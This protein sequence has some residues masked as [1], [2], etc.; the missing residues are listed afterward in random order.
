MSSS[1]PKTPPRRTEL[2][3]EV[4]LPVEDPGRF[5][6][7]WELGLGGRSIL[8]AAV[9]EDAERVGIKRSPF[10]RMVVLPGLLL[11][12]FTGDC[13]TVVPVPVND[14]SLTPKSRR[15]GERVAAILHFGEVAVAT[16]G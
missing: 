5:P 11:L 10:M 1:E 12:F 14:H 13:P 3:L 9:G 15:S 8:E 6:D 2:S 4:G 16:L 7:A